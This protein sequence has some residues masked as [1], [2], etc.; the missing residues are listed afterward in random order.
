MI[1]LA[2]SCTYLRDRISSRI[3]DL[4][5]IKDP[6]KIDKKINKETIEK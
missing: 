5:T 3:R 2:F 1:L 4:N 6:E